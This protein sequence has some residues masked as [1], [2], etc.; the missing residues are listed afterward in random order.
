MLLVFYVN[1]Y[2]FCAWP[3]ALIIIS[4]PVLGSRLKF[5]SRVLLTTALLRLSVFGFRHLGAFGLGSLANGG[6]ASGAS[7]A[8]E[9]AA[10][11]SA[12]V[13]EDGRFRRPLK[14]F[15]GGDVSGGCR[16]RP[17]QAGSRFP[18]GGRFLRDLPYQGPVLRFA[19][20]RALP[21]LANP[22]LPIFYHS[23]PLPV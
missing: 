12:A 17:L 2:K 15:G 16:K 3:P 10:V 4:T 13:T 5:N 18:K 11:M 1:I 6:F 23:Y 22:I 20:Y 7:R 8:A 9:R 21:F 19:L 14:K